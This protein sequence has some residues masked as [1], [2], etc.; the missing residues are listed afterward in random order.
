MFIWSQDVIITKSFEKIEAKVETITEDETH[1]KK[2]SNPNGPTYILKNNTIVSILFENG[3]IQLFQ[4]AIPKHLK[5]K[6][7]NRKT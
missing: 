5:L 4:K 3:E 2:T 1:Y 6:K 7:T